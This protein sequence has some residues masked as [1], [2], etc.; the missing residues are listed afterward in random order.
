MTLTGVFGFVE[1]DK[2]VVL[3]EGTELLE[4]EKGAGVVVVEDALDIGMAVEALWDVE[5]GFNVAEKLGNEVDAFVF[6][7]YPIDL[8]RGEVYLGLNL[9]DDEAENPASPPPLV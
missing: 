8:V 1:E 9:Y 4:V 6:E 3:V 5:D 7:L 2:G